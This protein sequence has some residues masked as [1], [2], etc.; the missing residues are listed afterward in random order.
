M[1]HILHKDFVDILNPLLKHYTTLE[2][3][4][5]G[6]STVNFEPTLEGQYREY[7]T[8]KDLTDSNIRKLRKQ[9]SQWICKHAQI[10]RAVA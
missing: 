6:H 4:V 3:D 5:Q 10:S 7:H 8:F 2:R 1:W 9:P